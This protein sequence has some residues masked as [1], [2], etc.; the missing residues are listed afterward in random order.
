[1]TELMGITVTGVAAR[2]VCQIWL[3]HRSGT[4]SPFI[5]SPGLDADKCMCGDCIRLNPSGV[6]W[7][8]QQIRDR[9]L[10]GRTIVSRA[11]KRLS[12]HD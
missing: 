10:N 9:V 8:D 3:K 12:R 1:M 6:W 4:P 11:E 7:V 5:A 2:Q